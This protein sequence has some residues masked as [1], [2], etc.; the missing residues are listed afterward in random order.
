[1][2]VLSHS[3]RRE[4]HGPT[5]GTSCGPTR[6]LSERSGIPRADGRA[7]PRATRR[8]SSTALPGLH[9]STRQALG[10]APSLVQARPP[11]GNEGRNGF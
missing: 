9:D 3:G 1:M 7:L 10:A 2:G 6:R 11:E 4:P 8:G 5:G